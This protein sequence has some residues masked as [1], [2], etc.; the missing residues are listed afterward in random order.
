MSTQILGKY[1]LTGQIVCVTG[2]HIGGSTVGM[3]IGGIDNPVIRDPMTDEP[4]IPGSSLKGKLRALTEWHLGLIA[5]HG[6]HGGYQAYACDELKQRQPAQDSPEADRWQNALTV[7]RLFGA[8]NDDSDVR[9]T[10]G[11]TRLTVRDSFLTETSKQTLQK[12][13]G[14]GSFT[15]LKTENALDRVTS[16]ANPRPLERIPA[17]SIFALS[18]IVDRYEKNDYELIKHLMAAMAL[19]EHSSLGGGGSRGSGQVAFD[20]VQIH[21]RSVQDY[22]S[23]NPGAAIKLPG[24]TVDKILNEFTNIEWT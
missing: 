17:G 9:F 21:W 15:E 14:Q 19:L 18:I 10:A 1:I 7:A 23:G 24:D 3:E 16:E 22:T 6:K 4:L 8:A 12:I 20:N 2:L 11:P 5:V 13:L